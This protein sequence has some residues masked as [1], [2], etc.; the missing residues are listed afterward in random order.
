MRSPHSRSVGGG[1]APCF[2]GLPNRRKILEEEEQDD[3]Q[4][5]EAENIVLKSDTYV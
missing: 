3:E 2:A 1:N 5:R 4:K